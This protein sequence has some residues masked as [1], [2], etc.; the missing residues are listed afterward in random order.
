M[1]N[2]L[3]L[4]A[5]VV[6][7]I[8]G[9]PI[10]FALAGA[11]ML[12]IWLVK[13]SFYGVLGIVGTA[14]YSSVADYIFTTIPTFVLMA[15]LSSASGL[16]RDLYDAA[17][18]WLSQLRGG[19]AIATV[20][21]SAIFGAM[22]GSSTA[23]ASVMSN[24]A[25]PQMRRVG[26]SEELASGSIAVGSVLNIL[27]PPSGAMII[28]GIATETSIAKLLIAGFLPGVVLTILLSLAIFIWV[29]IRPLHA[30]RTEP[31]LW[32]ERWRSLYRIWPSL[33][34]ILMVMILLYSGIATPTEV[35]ALGAFMAGVIGVALKRLTWSGIIEAIKGTVRI[36]TMI[37][38]IIIG[39][40]IFGYFMTLSKVPQLIVATLTEW[41]VNRYVIIVFIV[42][43]Y[44]A[45]SMFMDEIP[46]LLITLQ[47][48][49][50]LIIHLGFDPIWYGVLCVLMVSMGLIFPPVGMCA[51]VV[52][53]A[54]KVDLMKVYKGTSILVI[55]I[56]VTTLL[57]IVFPQI[58]LWLPSTMR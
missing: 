14:S 41:N 46:L 6:F 58:A 56:I 36:T 54:A 38:L 33:L 13:G 31:I 8:L 18:K 30:P 50:P 23:G 16:A 3:P 45:I 39:A 17:S 11:G 55:A 12:G 25:M 26:Y 9:V 7:L 48:T 40:N 34:L 51:F 19:L 44:F 52:S 57:V 47:V 10:A 42:A 37:F 28:Y 4:I 24:V 32:S 49:F 27:I 43:I 1:I 5:M 2:A 53:A 29:S 20:F 15:Y 21:A 22:S 35:G